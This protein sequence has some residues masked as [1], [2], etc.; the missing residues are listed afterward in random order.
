MRIVAFAEL[1]KFI[2]TPVKHYSSGM[3]VRLAFAVAAHLEPEILLVER[4]LRWATSVSRKN[5]WARW[6]TYP[7][8]A[9]RILV[10]H[11]VGAIGQLC[12][13]CVCWT[14]GLS[15]REITSIEVKRTLPSPVALPGTFSCSAACSYVFVIVSVQLVRPKHKPVV[16]PDTAATQLT[17][18]ANVVTDKITVRPVLIRRPSCPCIFSGN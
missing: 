6:T 1:E 17:D 10:S 12:R 3:Y 8:P 11:N 16:Q 18:G 2:D 5:A 14:T 4:S 15:L 7:R 9:H 13:R